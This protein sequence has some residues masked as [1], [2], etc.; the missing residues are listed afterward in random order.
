MPPLIGNYTDIRQL[1]LSTDCAPNC[2]WLPVDK[3]TLQRQELP[4]H[5]QQWL[6]Y[7][8]VI[9]ITALFLLALLAKCSVSAKKLFTEACQYAIAPSVDDPVGTLRFLFQKL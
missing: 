4:Q 5:L 2:T 6:N 7:I 1:G 8:H 3:L 9:I